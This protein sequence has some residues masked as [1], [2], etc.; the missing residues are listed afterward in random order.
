[1]SPVLTASANAAGGV[2]GKMISLQS[3]AVA[4]AATGMK[5][6][7]EGRLFAAMVRHSIALVVLL[8]VLALIFAYALPSLI[9]ELATAP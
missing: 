7:D 6:T 8:G 2:M 9:P 3:I 5:S 1:M 4:V